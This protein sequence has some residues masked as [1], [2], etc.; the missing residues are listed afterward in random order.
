MALA[1]ALRAVA[2]SAPPT[3]AQFREELD[4]AWVEAA[5]A[6]TGTA[7]LRRRRLPAEQVVWL[8]L[9]MALY[10]GR[11]VVEVAAALDLAL[12]GPRGP[13]ELTAAPSA[14]SQARARL[15]PE[16]LAWLFARGAA[17]WAHAGAAAHRWRGLA[18]YGVDGT[19]LRVA[20]TPAN[21]AHFGAQVAG[22]GR[23]VSAYP[24]A[25]VVALM[26]LRS[27][28]LAAAEFGPYGTSEVRYAAA[29]WPHVPNAS[30]TIVD[31]NFLA[32]HLLTPLAAG[33]A[34]RH[35]LVRAK[36]NTRATPVARLGEGDALVELEVSDHARR[37][38]PTLPRTWR[39][40]AITYERAGGGPQR[41]LTSL[42]DPVRYPA[43]EVVALYH[44]R[45]E[46]ELGYDELKTEL[47]EREEALRSRSPAAVMQELWGVLLA[48]NLV[49]LAMARAA[50][51]AGLAPTRLSFVG[52]LHLIRDEWLWSAY[53]APGAIPR[54]LA[55]LQGALARLVLPERRSD[56]VY[57]RAV[58]RKMSNYPRNRP[59]PAPAK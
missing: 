52:A 10:R 7:T 43:T 51:A 1:S 16:P 38:D 39:A 21:R 36:S 2:Q 31:R 34:E 58:K 11:S 23:G 49:R 15:G 18:L 25:R 44:E 33:G 46:L 42:L 20:D 48:Y 22:C 6:A 8:V 55:R 4:P 30:L 14:V 35:W 13:R 45:W 47:L 50:D 59:P 5:L 3:L 56:R 24:L 40:R 41:L 54:H 27:H 29:L 53:A 19:T 12:P 9:G 26:A 32:A 28:L 37:A 17:A 57:P